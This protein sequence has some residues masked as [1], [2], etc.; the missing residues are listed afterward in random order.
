MR[1]SGRLNRLLLVGVVVGGVAAGNA[2]AGVDK[3]LCHFT[4]ARADIPANFGVDVCFDAR[5]AILRNQL[6]LVLDASKSGDIG[7]PSREESDLGLAAAAERVHSHDRDIFLPGDKLTYPVGS[8]AGTL[9]VQNSK[10]NGFY[11]IATT[12][13]AFFP[14]KPAAWVNSFTALVA[15]LDAD[16]AHY[17]KC[18]AGKN[19][20]GQL[21]CEAI[22]ARDV[23][24]AA[25]RAGLS[26]SGNNLVQAIL[27]PATWTKWVD[28]N[29]HDLKASLGQS[30]V[31]RIAAESRQPQPAPSTPAPKPSTPRPSDTGSSPAIGSHFESWCVVAWPTAPLITTEGIQMTMSCDA[32]PESQYLFTEVAYGDPNLPISPEHARAYVIGQVVD[33]GESAYGYSE[34]VVEASSVEVEGG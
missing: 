27:S 19:F 13:A 10:D 30:G 29:V 6:T 7:N 11:A 21:G 25:G 17:A 14:G 12:I 5:N 1:L 3:G 4:Q 2:G 34:L 20:L 18:I 9:K 33:V 31:I 24:F 8:G 28:A 26:G 15:E 16:N 22:R 32:V 23:T